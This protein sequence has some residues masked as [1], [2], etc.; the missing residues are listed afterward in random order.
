ME[1]SGTTVTITCPFEDEPIHWELAGKA[2]DT[3]ERRLI[4]KDHDSTPANLSC[5]FRSG[6]GSG[7][8]QLYLNARGER[9]P[10]ACPPQGRFGGSRCLSSAG[11]GERGAAEAVPALRG[12]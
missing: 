3:T 4:L 10:L 8:H 6:E 9:S 5:S 2:Q 7:K 1:I 11:L 12:Q